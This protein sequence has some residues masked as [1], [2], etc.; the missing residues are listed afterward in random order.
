MAAETEGAGRG[1]Q[2]V[3]PRL[4]TGTEHRRN[5]EGI[6]VLV[7][8]DGA[9]YMGIGPG[10]EPLVSLLDGSRPL[11]RIVSA[12]LDARPQV[13]PMAVLAL[14]RRLYHADLLEGFGTE[15]DRLF[16]VRK[17]PAGGLGKIVGRLLDIRLQMGPLAAPLGIGR[18][19]PVGTWKSFH[20]LG[21]LALA[22]TLGFGLWAGSLR[23]LVDPFST[24]ATDQMP[25]LVLVALY[26]TAMAVLSLRGF[27]RGLLL[28][29]FGIPIPRAGVRVRWGVAHLDVDDRDRRAAPRSDRMQVSLVGLSCLAWVAAAGALSYLAWGDPI[30]RMACA[31][32][33]LTLLINATPF[34]ATD[35]RE[36]LEM[37][38]RVPSMR[39]R[40]MSYLLRRALLPSLKPSEASD[41]ENRYG[42]AASYWVAHATLAVVMLASVI[43]PGALDLVEGV[44][45]AGA[46]TDSPGW[47]VIVGLVVASAL[48]LTLVA[49]GVGFFV[50]LGAFFR[51]L[52]Q[53]AQR[54]TMARGTA[55]SDVQRGSFVEA[56][57]GIP[58]LSS[59]DE[60]ALRSLSARLQHE[61]YR[62]GQL[63]MRQGDPGDRFCFVESG[64]CAVEMEEASGISHQVAEIGPG[65]FFGEVSLVQDVPR[66]ATVRSLESVEILSLARDAFTELLAELDVTAED[67]LTQVRNAA[68]VRNHRLFAGVPATRMADLLRRLGQRAVSAGDDVVSQGEGGQSLYLVREGTF[69]VHHT[70]DEGVVR[71]VATL[72]VGEHFGEIALLGDG[73]R[74]A[75]V[76]AAC[77]GVVLEI[78]ADLFRDVLMKDFEAVLQLDRG[79]ADRLDLLQ[80]L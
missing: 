11:D 25:L 50:L 68:F 5:R 76:R 7:S 28:R 32:A 53:K 73:V 13:R 65:D 45:T 40:S 3:C 55:A 78:P 66:T 67:V 72:G 17:A 52:A 30:G 44:M 69:G 57:P 36:V 80:V 27:M 1:A 23:A 29:S 63:V 60:E 46:A 26:G 64:R 9:G 59:L 43:V 79:C 34:L 18:A 21:C 61:V 75:T 49:I 62:A 35:G 51:Q 20:I 42:L 48:V 33:T 8:P 2:I 39:R 71:Q 31:V 58:F 56:A 41:V 38:A 70:S 6:L 14:L 15:A 16:G 22:A 54:P 10:E 4:K 74:T 77:D 47:L 37:W 12:G 19:I 24:P